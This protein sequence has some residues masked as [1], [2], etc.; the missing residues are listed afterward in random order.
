MAKILIAIPTYDKKVDVELLS[1]IV[2]LPGQYPQHTIGLTFMAGSII[3]SARNNFCKVFLQ[4]PEL[5]WLYMWDADVVI[6]DL[7]FIDK[8][9]E[10]AEKLD[11]QIVGGLYRIKAPGGRLSASYYKDSSKTPFNS[12]N[13]KVGDIIEPQLVDCLATGSMLIKRE[14]LETIPEPWFEFRDFPDAKVWPEDY[15]FCDKAHAAGFQ[16]A[17][18]PRFDTYHYGYAAWPFTLQ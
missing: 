8:L 6:K 13:Y 9:L 11:A 7:T 18:D 12:D 1:T 15:V 14:V 2:A 4:N 3:Q 17:A 10:T 5:D 16:V